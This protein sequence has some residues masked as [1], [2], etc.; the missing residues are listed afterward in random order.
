MTDTPMGV[1]PELEAH[2]LKQET[3]RQEDAGHLSRHPEAGWPKGLKTVVVLVIV[4]ILAN[5]VGWF[6]IYTTGRNV[7]VTVDCN[8]A[9]R[10][11]EIT[12]GLEKGGIIKNG[13]ITIKPCDRQEP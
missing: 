10:L 3:E 5:T 4:A 7:I 2:V 8:N 1:D 6:M 11:G 12:Q 9:D 13:T